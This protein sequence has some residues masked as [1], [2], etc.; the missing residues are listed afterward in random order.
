M[1]VF[2]YQEDFGS[3]GI[4]ECLAKLGLKE[5]GVS[6]LMNLAGGWYGFIDVVPNGL[7]EMRVKGDEVVWDKDTFFV[8]GRRLA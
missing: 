2:W 1:K 7:P 8:E 3:F 5:S 4:I 6:S